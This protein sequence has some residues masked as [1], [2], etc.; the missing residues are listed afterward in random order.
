MKNSG[1]TRP[2]DRSKA[3]TTIATPLHK[4][5]NLSDPIMLGESVIIENSEHQGFVEG[6]GVGKILELKSFIEKWIQSFSMNFRFK[7]FHASMGG[8]VIRF[9]GLIPTSAGWITI[10]QSSV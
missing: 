9:M 8:L 1:S 3:K 2:S 5:T 6:V 10:G 7:L 4:N